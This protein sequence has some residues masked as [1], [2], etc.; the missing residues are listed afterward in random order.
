M[1]QNTGMVDS[2][3]TPSC[4]PDSPKNHPIRALL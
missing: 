2:A 1:D 3:T 4:H